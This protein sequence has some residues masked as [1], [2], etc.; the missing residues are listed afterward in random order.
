MVSDNLT[1][2]TGACLWNWPFWVNTGLTGPS[3]PVSA[4]CW[5]NKPSYIIA[6]N[7]CVLHATK[8]QK[9]LFQTW[10]LMPLILTVLV[11]G[12]L[13]SLFSCFLADV[14]VVEGKEEQGGGCWVK[15]WRGETRKQG[16]IWVDRTWMKFL[17]ALRV[18]RSPRS[19][20]SCTDVWCS[21][22]IF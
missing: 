17:T 20:Q 18:N 3:R 13:D 16:G 7:D 6:K 21:A 5:F 1:L 14:A 11:F 8:Q 12:S 22:F 4:D 15:R 2:S 10:P 9:Y 19:H